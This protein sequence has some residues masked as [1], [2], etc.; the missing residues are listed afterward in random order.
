[1]TNSNCG[2]VFIRD[3]SW[4]AWSVSRCRATAYSAT[5]SIRPLGWSPTDCV[6]AFCS[7]NSFL[8]IFILLCVCVC[9]NAGWY[10]TFVS[11]Y[12][13]EDPRQSGHQSSSRLVWHIS[14]RTARRSWNEGNFATT[15]R[16]KSPEFS[17]FFIHLFIEFWSI[18]SPSLINSIWLPTAGQRYCHH[19]LA[20]RRNDWPTGLD[21]QSDGHPRQNSACLKRNGGQRLLE[22]LFD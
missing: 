21:N 22:N 16:T 9:R 3:P 19:A 11:A 20:P 7:L 8:E 18:F 4:R 5:Q 15:A 6:R 17:I 14:I 12:S 10:L 13:F 2:S 1:M